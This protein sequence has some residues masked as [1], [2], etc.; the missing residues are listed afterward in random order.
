MGSKRA[1]PTNLLLDRFTGTT[2]VVT[3]RV[4]Q[5]LLPCHFPI[6]LSAQRGRPPDRL[7][8]GTAGVRPC[9]QVGLAQAPVGRGGVLGGCRDVPE[10]EYLG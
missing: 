8:A 7:L 9:Q 4:S 5:E 2:A 6:L 10:A 3:Q 1:G